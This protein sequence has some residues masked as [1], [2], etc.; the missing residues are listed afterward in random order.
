ML[1]KGPRMLCIP[2]SS[3]YDAINIYYMQL[4]YIMGKNIINNTNNFHIFIIYEGVRKITFKF[5]IGDKVRI[6]QLRN[7]FSREYDE[8]LTEVFNISSRLRR[9]NSPINIHSLVLLI[10]FNIFRT[11][12]WI[13]F[14]WP[15]QPL[16]IQLFVV[17]LS[18]IED[19]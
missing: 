3:L 7:I 14:M 2:L 10:V 15:I 5:K 19:Y 4:L 8:K 13:K 16:N 17:T 6:T 18:Y 1:W 9:S 11:Y 12:P